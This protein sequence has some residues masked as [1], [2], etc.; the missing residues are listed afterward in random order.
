[1]AKIAGHVE[2]VRY[3]RSHSADCQRC[4]GER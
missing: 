2:N 4:D 1:M 3:R